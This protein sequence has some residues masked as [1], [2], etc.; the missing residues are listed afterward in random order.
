MRKAQAG[1]ELLLLVG[2][3]AIV[4]IYFIAVVGDRQRIAVEDRI[5]MGGNAV[6]DQLATEINIAS[7]IGD[8]YSRLFTLPQKLYNFANYTMR[9]HPGS[10][11]VEVNWRGESCIR[12]IF[13]SNVTGTP[14]HGD[15]IIRNAGGMIQLG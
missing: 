13:T 7:K 2:L 1:V 4:F 11:R 5:S 12:A 3:L 14:Q 9:M 15:N 8:G 10:Q 6:C